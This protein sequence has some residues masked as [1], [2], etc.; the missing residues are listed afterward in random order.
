LS[1]AFEDF[2]M[3]V[4]NQKIGI[5]EQDLARFYRQHYAKF[6]GQVYRLVRNPSDAEDIVQFSFL[7][8]FRY[9]S[10]FRQESHVNT[11]LYTIVM[12]TTRDFLRRRGKERMSVIHL[13]DLALTG[14]KGI[15]H[16]SEI[17]SVESNPEAMLTEPSQR[18][19]GAVLDTLVEHIKLPHHREVIRMVREG[20]LIREIADEL[21]MPVSSVCTS[22]FNIAH[23]K[24]PKLYRAYVQETISLV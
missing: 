8:A 24:L 1:M 5:S 18:L 9:R 16:I 4:D 7:K 15:D 2:S 3:S 23:W 20:Y 12:N 22:L 13:D 10:Y 19:A 14:E 17:G 21:D 6:V 11:W